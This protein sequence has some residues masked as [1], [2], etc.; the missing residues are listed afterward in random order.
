M[1]PNDTRGT[2]YN[3]AAAAAAAGPQ[4]LICSVYL[5]VSASFPVI[6][7]LSESDSE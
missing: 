4:P 3:A 5:T 6:P 7:K 1:G 2:D